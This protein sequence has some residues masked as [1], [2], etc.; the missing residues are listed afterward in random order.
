[1]LT[2]EEF[3]EDLSLGYCFVTIEDLLEMA[4]RSLNLKTVRIS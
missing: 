4:G 1:M 2:I 3:S